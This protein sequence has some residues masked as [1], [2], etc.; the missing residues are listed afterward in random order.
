[1]G[2]IEDLLNSPIP[3]LQ[4]KRTAVFKKVSENVKQ[5]KIDI[6]CLYVQISE[7]SEYKCIHQARFI[8]SSEFY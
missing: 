2:E 4:W 1:M 6:H 7:I 3:I 8:Q 5:N